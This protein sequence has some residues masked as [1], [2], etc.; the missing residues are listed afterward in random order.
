MFPT[1]VIRLAGVIESRS[2]RTT[3]LCECA[4]SENRYLPKI[5]RALDLA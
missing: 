2:Q 4:G 5:R 3:T 1:G